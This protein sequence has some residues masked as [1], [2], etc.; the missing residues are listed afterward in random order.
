MR[1]RVCFLGATRYSCPLDPT[2]ERKFRL[3]SEHAEIFV[4][5]FA[6]GMRPRRF[7][8]HARFYLLP[9]PPVAVLRYLILLLL[10]PLVALWCVVRHRARILVAQSPYE[11]AAAAAV[12]LCTRARLV[13]ENHG[14][15]EVSLFLQRQVAAPGFYRA[16]MGPVARFALRHADLF[17]AISSSTREQLSRWAPGK[18]I[19]EFPTWTD[20]D[21]FLDGR[22]DD[23]ERV[24]YVGVQIPR[25]GI[26]HL[27]NAFKAV[28]AEFPAARL[29]IV[30][31]EEN[32]EYAAQLK[33]MG[34]RVEFRPEMPQAELAERMRRARVLVLPS[35]SEALGRVVVEAMAAG[36]PVIGSRVGGIPDM[37]RDGE[38]GFL[39]EPG[40]EKTLAERLRW[41][42]SRRDDARAMG[43]RGREFARRFFSSGAYVAGYRRIF[44]A[45]AS[46]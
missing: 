25:K 12:K 7:R 39:V 8:Q 43:E 46:L 33:S 38:T 6:A 1:P 37:V 40:D 9:A 44:D 21:V 11:G 35:L 45:A 4:V 16:I 27:V 2:S 29:E 18:P 24:L 14:D 34:G 19:V 15:F 17:R 10:G 42:L 20:L 30:G 3:L 36:T 23:E 13:V 41:M 26:H 28:E 32:P 5:G 22:R 31:R